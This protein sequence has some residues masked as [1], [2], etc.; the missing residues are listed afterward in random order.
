MRVNR[1][2]APHKKVPQAFASPHNFSQHGQKARAP[3][4]AGGGSAEPSPVTPFG[5]VRPEPRHGQQ[6][7]SRPTTTRH[8]A[9]SPTCCPSIGGRGRSWSGSWVSGAGKRTTTAPPTG[10]QT[11]S[12]T[13]RWRSNR[14]RGL[15]RADGNDAQQL[16]RSPGAGVWRRAVARAA[17][18]G[19]DRRRRLGGVVQQ[20]R[21]GLPG[22][23]GAAAVLRLSRARQHPSRCDPRRRWRCRSR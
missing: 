2:A 14:R 6:R 21:G 11:R 7:G 5:R 19:A 9:A 23:C 17:G 8:G 16:R 10:S 13:C 18:L 12:A 22:L 4:P 15:L 1:H 3:G 20:G